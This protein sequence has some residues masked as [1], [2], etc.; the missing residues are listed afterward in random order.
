MYINAFYSYLFREDLFVCLKLSVLVSATATTYTKIQLSLF[1]FYWEHKSNQINLQSFK[2]TIKYLLA[3]HFLLFLFCTL[4]VELS[5]TF[6]YKLAKVLDSFFF[7][8]FS[9]SV[10]IDST[11][12][13]NQHPKLIQDIKSE[14]F[15]RKHCYKMK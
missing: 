14:S 9:I 5:N 11:E 3:F 2:H 6:L 8:L 12:L 1:C 7:Q 15:L 4:N 10:T 13:V